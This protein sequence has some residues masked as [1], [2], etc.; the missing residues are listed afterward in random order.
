[1]LSCRRARSAPPSSARGPGRAGRS[2]AGSV[3]MLMPAAVLVVMVLGAIA[4]DLTAVRLGQRELV[5]A[6]GDAANDAVTVGLDEAALRRG[7]GYRLDA[8]RAE[9]AVLEALAA[10]GLLDELSEP[11]SVT[12]TGDGG[13]EVRLVRRVPHL[14]A[15]ALPGA[16]DDVDVRATVAARVE[17]R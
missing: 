1:M 5:A 11:P 16:P 2:D 8:T 10:K 17:R 12:V 7:D 6:A 15:K 4:V 9:Q 14:F 13:V 3:L